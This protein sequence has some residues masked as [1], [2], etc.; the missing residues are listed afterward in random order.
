MSGM[1]DK[2]HSKK[3]LIAIIQTFEIPVED[4]F[5]LTKTQLQNN[6]IRELS[7]MKSIKPDYDEYCIETIE[8]LKEYLKNQNQL[9]VLSIKD[10]DRI[11][12]LSKFI[13]HYCKNNYMIAPSHFKCIDEIIK[14]GREISQYGDVP[15]ARRAVE[16]LNN[17]PKIDDNFKIKISPK[18]EKKLKEKQE[19]RKIETPKI[20]VNKGFY[21]IDFD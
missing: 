7:N 17:D 2:S 21:R 3:E 5:D 11:M 1:I 15:T 16:L 14:T 6:L 19:I 4:M 12:N 8:Q 20:K 18:I 13:I 10:K 9:K